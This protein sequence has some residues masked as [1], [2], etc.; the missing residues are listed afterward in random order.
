MLQICE[1]LEVLEWNLLDVNGMLLDSEFIFLNSTGEEIFFVFYPQRNRNIVEDLQKLVEFLLSKLSHTDRELVQRAYDIYELFL[2]ENFQV[3]ELKYAILKKRMDQKEVYQVEEREEL[4]V[5]ETEHVYHKVCTAE[6]SGSYLQNQVEGKLSAWY[7]RA[8]ELL[9]RHPKEEIPAVV[10]PEDEEETIQMT[11]YPTLCI[12][13]T[14]GEPRGILMYEGMGS[15]PDIE[16]QQT[17][18]V[19][20]KSI[21]ACVQIPKD[22]ISN[23]HAKIEYQNG[24]YYIEDMNS[25]NGTFVNDE[26]LNYREKRSL[27]PGDVIRFAD[28]KYRFL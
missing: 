11:N 25:T 28:L 22:T 7:K 26:I 21:H 2:S 18:C 20:G 17:T 15:Y 10:Y 13:T 23:I 5:G 14:L 4:R 27:N 24:D 8:K 1:Q 3:E 6:V 12:A 19:I 9:I 16:L